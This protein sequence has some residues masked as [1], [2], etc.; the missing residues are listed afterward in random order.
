[1]TLANKV[2]PLHGE[3]QFHFLQFKNQPVCHQGGYANLWGDFCFVSVSRQRRHTRATLISISAT[4]PRT[5]PNQLCFYMI[6]PSQLIPAKILWLKLLIKR[7]CTQTLRD[8]SDYSSNTMSQH[9]GNAQPRSNY[10][11]SLGPHTLRSPVS[12][13]A[14]VYALSIIA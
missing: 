3:E 9:I 7:A 4:D 11:R 14:F 6:R 1:M 13:S 2:T 12:R 5:C 8:G 10:T